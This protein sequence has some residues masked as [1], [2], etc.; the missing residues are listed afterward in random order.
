MIGWGSIIGLAGQA[1]G[2]WLS[3]RNNDEQ[4]KMADAAAARKEAHYLAKAAEDP[5]SRSENRAL[6]HQYDR[7]AQ[8]QVEAA[9]NIAAITGATPEYGVAVQEG[10][11][12]G[13]SDLMGKMAAGASARADEYEQ[14]AEEVRESKE[15]ADLERKAA[16]QQSFANLVTNAAT[17]AGNIMD[18]Y[19]VRQAA[20]AAPASAAP[21]APAHPLN[22]PKMEPQLPGL[23]YQTMHQKL[24]A[25]T[26]P[27][28]LTKP[29]TV[30]LSNI[31]KD[32]YS[33]GKTLS[34]SFLR[35]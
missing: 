3:K 27:K 7:E 29:T 31:R 23:Q 24:Q 16:R 5:L 12:R 13:R 15:A 32:P 18:S 19:S 10:V 17:A 2:S 4:Q 11:A 8:E 21:A 33:W 30:D 25:A 9:R 20:P 34:L 14:K 26:A 22:V 1:L 35:K 6:L 28:P